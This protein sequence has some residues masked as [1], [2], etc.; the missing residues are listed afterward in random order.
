MVTLKAHFDGKT[1][2][3]DEPVDLPVNQPL[4]VIL[5][6]TS[7][8]Q[9]NRIGPAPGK[10]RPG[11]Q[12]RIGIALQGLDERPRQHDPGADEDALWEQKGP[13][14]PSQS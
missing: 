7:A 9:A 3:P 2:V 8:S 11:W 12:S 14:R 6:E 4:H 13:T 5:L 1:I 10:P